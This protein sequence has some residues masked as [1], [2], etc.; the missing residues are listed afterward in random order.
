MS[1]QPMVKKR[2]IT[3]LLVVV[4]FQLLFLGGI[5]ASYYAVGWFGNEIKIKTVPVDPRDLLYGDY[6]TLSYEISNLAPQLWAESSEK[7]KQGDQV[8]VLLQP[9]KD[10]LYEAVGIY[11][12][13]PSVSSGQAV[14]KGTVD[15]S[16]DEMIHIK[17]GLERYYV[18][19]GTGQVLEDQARNMIVRVKIA[20]WGQSRISGLEENKGS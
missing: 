2:R 6:V 1:D 12:K 3:L 4:V 5:A 13:Q 16:W 7:P 18:P 8:Y 17:Y 20:P 10:Q 19:E 14:L 15:Y 11:S 9:S